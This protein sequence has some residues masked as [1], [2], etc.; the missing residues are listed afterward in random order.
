MKLCRLF[1][2]SVATC[3]MSVIAINPASAMEFWLTEVPPPIRIAPTTGEDA[4]GNNHLKTQIV[5]AGGIESSSRQI[6]LRRGSNAGKAG[7]SGTGR[8]SERL[9]VFGTRGEVAQ[10]VMKPDKGILTSKVDLPHQGIFNV[11]FEEPMSHGDML[12]LQVAKIELVYGSCCEKGADDWWSNKPIVN[13][14]L[15]LELIREQSV[16]EKTFTQVKSGDELRIIVM[17]YGRPVAGAWVGMT[18]RNG[19]SDSK[20]SDVD[21]HVEFSIDPN[22]IASWETG[23]NNWQQ[24]YLLMAEY[25]VASEVFLNGVRYKTAHYTSS[26]SGTYL[27]ISNNQTSI[28][29]V[30]VAGLLLIVGGAGYIWR[31]RR[32]KH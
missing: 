9:A 29:I 20:R 12:H 4:K 13:E 31:R 26:L 8:S 22:R 3:W 1:S 17:S 30:M 28:L 5:A 2:W 21:G 15:P 16:D 18:T 11:Y 24:E 27:P 6:W 10:A 25:D 19:W 14:K 32:T 7:Y 23:S